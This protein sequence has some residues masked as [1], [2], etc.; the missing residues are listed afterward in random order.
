MSERTRFVFPLKVMQW[1]TLQT[2]NGQKL[3]PGPDM[4]AVGYIPVYDGI[5]PL[6]DDHGHDAE[7]GTFEQRE[8]Q[9]G[10]QHE[11]T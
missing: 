9:N 2:E 5:E 4:K 7:F 11:S 3:N 6:C 1:S 10:E 8:Q